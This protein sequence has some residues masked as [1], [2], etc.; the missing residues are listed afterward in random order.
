M[1]AR[2]KEEIGVVFERDP[3][4]R[5]TW[6]VVT[7]YPGFHAMLVHR[8]SHRLW[9]NGL[10]WLARFVSHLGRWLTGVEIHP[11]AHIGRRFFIDH[12]MGVVIGE[13]A[14]VGDDVMLYHGVTLG[15]KAPRGTPR[16][17]KRHPTLEDG[18]TV[19]AGAK[20]LG[21]VTIGAWSAIGANA[22]VTKDAPAH[23]LVVGI[24][25]TFKP[26]SHETA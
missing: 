26:L 18:V 21:D 8:L 22:V 19:G 10:K 13:T 15:G 4:A 14:V 7:C 16:G 6:E 24:P 2:L 25:A 20:V 5:N 17:A 1:F 23:S 11:G 12:G 3:A 9:G